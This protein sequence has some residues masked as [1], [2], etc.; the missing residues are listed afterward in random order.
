MSNDL[1]FAYDLAQI[2]PWPVPRRAFVIAEVGINHNGDIAL[3]KQLI[4]MARDVGCDAVKFQKRTVERVYS[5]EVLE[6]P[7]ESPWGTTTRAQKEALEFGRAAYDEIDAFCREKG[8]IW[9]AS[10][11]D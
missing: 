3:A 8:I 1:D 5:K 7:R 4:A 10:A 9:F 2:E 6:S 11:W